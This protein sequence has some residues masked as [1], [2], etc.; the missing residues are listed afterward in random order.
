MAGTKKAAPAKKKAAPRGGAAAKQGKKP[1]RREVG[2]TVC[3]FLAVFSILWLCNVKAIFIDMVYGT[4]SGIIGFGSYLLPVSLLAACVILLFHRGNPVRLRVVS[5]LGIAFLM[6]AVLHLFIDGNVYSG[7]WKTVSQLMET[8]RA[9]KSGGVFGG[10]VAIGAEYIFSRIGA[11]IL[12][13][14]GTVI[15]VFIAFKI[16]VID[17]YEYF[18]KREKPEYI[19]REPAVKE[20]AL[21]RAEKKQEARRPVIDIPL[22]DKPGK[23]KKREEKPER[24]ETLLAKRPEHIKPPDEVLAQPV[25]EESAAETVRQA[26]SQPSDAHE[27]YTISGIPVERHRPRG[28]AAAIPETESTAPADMSEKDRRKDEEIKKEVSESLTQAA[29]SQGT[30][31]YIYP[32]PDLLA[33]PKGVNVTGVEEELKTNAQR[34]TD[35]IKS[36]GIEARIINVTRGPSVTRY[37]LELDRGIKL[38]KLT[39]LS[40]DIALSLGASSVRIAPI[41]HKV[42][43]VGIEVPNKIVTTV[44]MREL[45]ESN[46]F[47]KS[48]SKVSF[49]LGK[50]IGGEAI[51]GDIAKLPHMLIAGTTGSGKSVCMNSLIISMLYKASPDEVRLIM[52]DPKMIELNMYNGIPHLLIPVV[53]DPKKASGALQWA[54]FEMMRRYKLFA[55][56]NVRDIFA[57]NE[58]AE[59]EDDVEK[60][61]QIVIVIDELADLMLVAAKEVE[62]SICRIAQMARAAGMHLVIA[63]QRPSADVI[64]GIM[65]AN[66]PSRIAFAVA[67]Q[68][69]S[70]IILDTTGAEKLVGKGDMLFFPLGSGKPQR[71]QGCFITSG[72]V[73]KVVGFVKKSGQ[74]DYSKEVIDHIEKAA[75]GEKYGDGGSDDS[76]DAI[77]EVFTQAVEIILETSQASVSML[78]RRLKLG[79]ARAARLVDQMEAR[80]IVGPFE[81]AKPRQLLITRGEWEEMKL[82]NPQYQ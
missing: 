27:G 60:L 64:T 4:L 1:V 59:M 65:K 81:G 29:G 21:P 16:S 66:I 82:Q 13:I 58:L 43:V 75:S 34:L 30:G 25:R 26:Q 78:Q 52:I 51:V 41:P 77:D 70:R 68:L 47:S 72:E 40:D 31:S 35:T 28:S 3:F 15:L 6:G 73:E 17:I 19:P 33:E 20:E 36:F 32:S 48:G 69:E 42:A 71:I 24:Q 9:L 44:Y 37:E 76:N 22:D 8:G 50:D 55:E 74:L 67:S 23:E 5:V 57:Y 62:E 12:L 61:P 10:L 18:S 38:T 54:V 46:E 63:T 79:Y 39:G 53:T 14:V 49:A 80:G 7:G 56:T 2:S 45:I 11:S